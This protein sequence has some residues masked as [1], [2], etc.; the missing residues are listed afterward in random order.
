LIL[1]SLVTE[2]EVNGARDH[3]PPEDFA[4]KS[5]TEPAAPNTESFSIEEL[6]QES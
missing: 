1:D 2:M 5:E 3:L 4:D 6:N